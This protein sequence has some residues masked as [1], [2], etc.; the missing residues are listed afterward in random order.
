MAVLPGQKRFDSPE[1]WRRHDEEGFEKILICYRHWFVHA[2]SVRTISCF[3][4]RQ[5]KIVSPYNITGLLRGW[6]RDPRFLR[7]YGYAR[8]SKADRDDKNLEAQLQEQ[9]PRW[10]PQGPHLRRRRGRGDFQVAGLEGAPGAR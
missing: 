3:G 7:F 4:P 2:D 9:A 1:T 8:V 6:S 5:G 10:P